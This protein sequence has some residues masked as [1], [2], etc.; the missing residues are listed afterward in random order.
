MGLSN[1]LTQSSTVQFIA[2]GGN[3]VISLDCSIKETHK[4]KAVA[5]EFEVEDGQTISDHFIIKPVGLAITG[6]ITDTPLSLLSNLLTTGVTAV[7]G[8]LGGAS[9][10]GAAAPALALAPALGGGQSSS[11]PSVAAYLQLLQIMQS[12]LPINV[13]TSLFRY[14]NLWITEIT[15]PRDSKTGKCLLFDMELTQLLLVAPK[16]VNIAKY[17]DPDVAASQAD[18]GKQSSG[19]LGAG[20]QAG[21]SDTSSVAKAFGVQ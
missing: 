13:L 14:K 19:A 3:T 20:F 5:T 9:V 21:S 11:S 18:K 2:Q 6:M 15:V 1:L 8:K 12:A 4:R 10:L 16:T 17:A 7:V